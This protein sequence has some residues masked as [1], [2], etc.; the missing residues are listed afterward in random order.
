MVET[1]E[2]L[3]RYSRMWETPKHA[4]GIWLFPWALKSTPFSLFSVLERFYLKTASDQPPPYHSVAVNPGAYAPKL[5]N[6]LKDLHNALTNL[7]R[8]S[9]AQMV[10]I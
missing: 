9:E 8:H 6:S 10:Q 7:G 3:V 5:A 2:D 1:K 4:F